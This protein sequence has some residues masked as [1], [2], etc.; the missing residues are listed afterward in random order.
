MIANEVRSSMSTLSYSRSKA[1]CSIPGAVGWIHSCFSGFRAIT[2]S[3]EVLDHCRCPRKPRIKRKRLYQQYATHALA[4]QS[5]FTQL[6]NRILLPSESSTYNL[7]RA[8]GGS[9]QAGDVILLFGDL[10]VG[11]TILARGFIHAAHQDDSIA[12][13]SPSYLLINS[14]PYPREQS[15]NGTPDILHMDLWRIGD[16]SQRPIVDFEKAFKQSVCLIEWPE[17]LKKLTPP[18]RL[19]VHMYYEKKPAD[20][21]SSVDDPWGFGAHDTEGGHAIGRYAQLLPFGDKWAE[22][23]Q[24]LL[25]SLA[26]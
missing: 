11:K 15:V 12:V 13:T 5:A 4:S 21:V 19:E 20:D 25:Q 23:V 1:V 8:L 16:A 26:G 3:G 22:R 17:R 9:C 14:Y 18:T 7:G 24:A 2:T 10:G 6:E